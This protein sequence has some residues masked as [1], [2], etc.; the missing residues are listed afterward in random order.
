MAASGSPMPRSSPCGRS[1]LEHVEALAA[2]YRAAR[3][4]R[5]P[6]ALLL[7]GLRLRMGARTPE[8]LRRLLEGMAGTDGEAGTAA[9]RVLRAL[10][11][12]RAPREK[13]VVRLS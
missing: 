11:E 3:A 10:A 2:A 6:A 1:P 13:E 9:R 8:E 4:S 7:E 5:R 12:R